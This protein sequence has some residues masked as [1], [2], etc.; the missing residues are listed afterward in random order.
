VSSVLQVAS[1]CPACVG[2]RSADL[3]VVG[4]AGSDKALNCAVDQHGSAS[5][6]LNP[7]E[8][9]HKAERRLTPQVFLKRG[10]IGARL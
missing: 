5:V 1:K 8:Q 3:W 2:N 10:H 4:L 9:S 7:A 6:V